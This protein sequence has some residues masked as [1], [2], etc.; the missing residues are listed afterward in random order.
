MRVVQAFQSHLVPSEQ[1]FP[2]GVTV[3]NQEK[4]NGKG[5]EKLPTPLD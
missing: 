2:T 3:K 1:S 4:A 5:K